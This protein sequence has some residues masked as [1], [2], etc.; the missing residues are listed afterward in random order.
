[1]L[2]STEPDRFEKLRALSTMAADD[3]LARPNPVTKFRRDLTPSS[4][5]H[6]Y[7]DPYSR[8]DKNTMPGVYKASMSGGKTISLMR[9]MFT[10]F[11]MM[12][13]HFCPNSHWVPRKRFAY[14]VD[15]LAKTFAE[16]V[17][18]NMVN[19]LFLSSGI[20]G[21]GAARTTQKMVETVEVIRKRYGF[22]GYVHLKVMPGTSEDIV[23]AAHRLGTRLSVNIETPSI[24]GLQSLSPMKD[25]RSGI[26]D[27]MSWIDRMAKARTGEAVGQATQMIVGAA[28]ESDAD[29]LD[30]ITQLYGDWNLKRVYYVPFRPVRYTPMEEHEPTPSEREHRL[31]QV[32]WL[33]RVYHFDND[34]IRLAFDSRGLLD[35]DADPKAVIALERPEKFPVDVNTA[36][37]NLL[38]RTPGIGPISAD[39]ILRHRRRFTIDNWRDLQVMGVVR[40]KAAGFIVMPGHRPEPARQLRMQ[41]LGHDEPRSRVDLRDVKRERRSLSVP[42]SVAGDGCT[43]QSSCN[44]CPL[45]GAPGHPGPK[46]RTMTPAAT[47]LPVM[48]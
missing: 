12:D 30:R 39:R 17:D 24:S 3:V 34:E 38:L 19:G 1:M 15:E 46:S 29:I 21:S 45:F 22:K 43:D 47:L 32:D 14:K 40:K 11:C 18:R 10:D 36:D 25:M 35:L 48:A 23:E 31:Y 44:T 41:M 6:T 8:P 4:D 16:M 27:P 7:R 13:C 42:V 26:L 2:I 20:M 37:L 5:G 28:G 33:K 9:T